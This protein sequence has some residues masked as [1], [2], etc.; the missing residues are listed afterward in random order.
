M[1]RIIFIFLILSMAACSDA[2]QKTSTE[3]T[4]DTLLI[5]KDSSMEGPD[6]LI[7]YPLLSLL[8]KTPVEIGCILE[9]EFKYRDSVFN[10][11]Y[12]NYVNKGDPC[13][14][15]DEYY[16]GLT[17]PAELFKK[18][19]PAIKEI[20]LDFEHGSLRELTITFRDSLLKD[21]IR[22]MFNLPAE[23]GT[24]PDNIMIINFGENVFSNDKP[25]DPN[26][27]RW[28]TV[29]GFEHMGA[30]DVDCK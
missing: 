17:I 30:G 10:C 7:K 5:A 18:I 3:T 21:K 6:F 11:D 16:E 12:K 13:V 29:T 28:L 2:G 25:A 27:T 19:N 24:L 8:R 4:A 1:N 22:E 26:Y 20:N 14:K 9:T 15:T 23:N